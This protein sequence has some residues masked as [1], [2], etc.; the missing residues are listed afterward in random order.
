MPI[1]TFLQEKVRDPRVKG[2]PFSDTVEENFSINFETSSNNPID[3][4]LEF[5]P[6]FDND[7]IT[8]SF[9]TPSQRTHTFSTGSEGTVTFN[10]LRTNLN[11]TINYD[12][13][14]NFEITYTNSSGQIVA[15]TFKIAYTRESFQ[16]I[17][18]MYMNYNTDAEGSWAT[19]PSIYLH[20]YLADSEV[21]STK[22]I[23]TNAVTN[24]KLGNLSVS[25]SKI[26]DNAV[27]SAK[28]NFS[29]TALTTPTGE[30]TRYK[31]T[32]N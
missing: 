9:L 16:Y 14:R 15:A 25:T 23:A 24:T 2:A 3:I 30:L 12:G 6:S 10:G 4:E 1:T 29:R 28:I 11:V 7:S 21:V 19:T 22:N 32:I 27:T 8:F 26:A 13:R 17:R 31:I 5:D 20:G 18:T